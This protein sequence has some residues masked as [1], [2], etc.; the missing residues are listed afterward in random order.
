MHML[1]FEIKFVKPYYKLAN[2]FSCASMHFTSLK[3]V[4]NRYDLNCMKTF[5]LHGMSNLQ[6]KLP[7]DFASHYGTAKE[8]CLYTVSLG[9]HGPA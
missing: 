8:A 9:F 3:A 7:S 1:Q 5:V 4:D 6:K 2:F